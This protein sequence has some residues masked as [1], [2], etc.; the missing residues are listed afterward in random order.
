MTMALTPAD[1]VV[2]AIS[3]SVNMRSD[4]LHLTIEEFEVIKKLTA[5]EIAEVEAMVRVRATR[6]LNALREVKAIADG[7]RD[8]A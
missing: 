6:W 3:V 5:E 1:A 4:K 8:V 7:R 2:G